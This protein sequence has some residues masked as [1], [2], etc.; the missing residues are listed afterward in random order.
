M[1]PPTIGDWR[2]MRGKR[3]MVGFEW[4]GMYQPL[5]ERRDGREAGVGGLAA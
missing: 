3:N 2:V 1:F 5:I 4:V